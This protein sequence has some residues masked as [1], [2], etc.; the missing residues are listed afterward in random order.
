VP[1]LVSAAWLSTP[2]QKL[3][4][5]DPSNSSIIVVIHSKASFRSKAAAF[6]CFSSDTYIECRDSS[7]LTVSPTCHPTVAFQ[8]WPSREPSRRRLQTV[9]RLSV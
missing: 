2:F 6:V 3:A 5:M 9:V 4:K 1:V 8:P 7:P